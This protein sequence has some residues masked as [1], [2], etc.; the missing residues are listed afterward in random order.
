MLLFSRLS[1]QPRAS[2]DMGHYGT[3]LIC[4]NGHLISANSEILKQKDSYC[5]DCGAEIISVCDKC[6]EP[7]RGKFL[8]SLHVNATTPYN[9]VPSHCPYCG[10]AYPWMQRLL[11]KTKRLIDLEE[12][13]SEQEKLD[14][15]ES[16]KGIMTESVSSAVNASIF[17]ILIN[18]AGGFVR[19]SLYQLAIDVASETAKKII[20][21]E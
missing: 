11:D 15:Y 17:K 12:S 16:A 1:T 9:Y 19:D 21:R 14:L 18:K 7:I 2:F 6:N 5:Q 4:K 20:L 8:S 13:L 10:F 3:A